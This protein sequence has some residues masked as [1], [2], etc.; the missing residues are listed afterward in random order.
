M[1]R[2]ILE[3]QQRRAAIHDELA[4]YS[5][6]AK[7]AGDRPFTTEERTKIDALMKESDGLKTELAS[8][9]GDEASRKR[10][11]DLGAELSES[12]G[13]QTQPDQLGAARYDEQ[14]RVTSYFEPTDE[15]V[16]LNFGEPRD[17]VARKSYSQLRRENHKQLKQL[18]YQPWGAFKSFRE[19]TREGL[20]G[21]GSEALAAKIGKHYEKL[22]ISGMS[23]TVGTDGGYLLMPEM[24]SGII[25]RVYN[26]DLWSRTD[27]YTIGP[28]SNS[29]TFVANA[30]TSRATGSRHGGLR[31]YWLGEG[32]TKTASKPTFRSINLKL[33][34][35]AV[36]VYL[37]DE[38]LEDTGN[39][40]SQYVTRKASEEFNFMIGDA[41]VN[42]NGVGQPLGLLNWPSLVSV[43][44]EAGQL[45]DTLETE[46]IIKMFSRFYGPNRS[47]MLWLHNQDIE[48]ELFTMTLG[49]GTGG[50]VTYMPPGGLSSAP[51]ATLM[52][53]PMI[54]T[55]F[56]P[57]LGDQGDILAADLGQ[58]LSISKGG[59]AQA[60]S[61]HVQFLTDQTALR[62]VM[63]LNAGPWE[64]APLTPFKG[65][66]T[67]SNAVTLDARA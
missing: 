66:L 4:T 40:L 25:D 31:G 21:N 48:P 17:A 60:V 5:K 13:R 39:V 33:M 6:A 45:A 53:R 34:K 1:A 22:A 12:A 30:E 26:N 38:L 44:K 47:N 9:E 56:N 65:T 49:V 57:T 35:L 7:L 14:G 42:G 61:I 24:A 64:S 36:V 18:G 20:S 67:Q 63:R 19:F 8:L 41:L 23:E 59:I 58:M 50:V 11:T 15:T 46:N 2:T 16:T 32:A 43:A 37:T 51:Y 55:E 62:F 27:N 54:P 3:K 28:N 29:M 52:G 10:I